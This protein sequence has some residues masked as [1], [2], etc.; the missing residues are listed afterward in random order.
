MYISSHAL[1]S[2]FDILIFKL[3]TRLVGL[4]YDKKVQTEREQGDERGGEYIRDH[5]PMEA[6]TA[7][8]YG[9]DFRI[10]RHLGGKENH[11][12]EHEQRTEHI[13]E[14]R[15]EIQVIIKYDG[16]ERCLLADKIINLLTDIEDDDDADDEQQRHK[17]CRYEFLD[18]V[19][20][21]TSRSEVE[22]HIKAL[23]LSF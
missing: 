16:L 23:L 4:R 3:Q 15:D 6:D 7:G 5:H 12:N 11:R 22:L 2:L 21:K 1:E 8:E 18:Y 14:V 20:V 13:H 10:R 9:Y 17:E 19:N